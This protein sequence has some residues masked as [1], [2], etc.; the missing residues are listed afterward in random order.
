MAPSLEVRLA[1]TELEAALLA[2]E[3]VPGDTEALAERVSVATEAALDLG[4]PV[5]GRANRPLPDLV[6][7]V[8]P[9]GG[10]IIRTFPPDGEHASG[11]RIVEIGDVDTLVVRAD[12]NEEVSGLIRIGQVVGLDGAGSGRPISAVV[13]RVSVD[14]QGRPVLSAVFGPGD[15][16]AGAYPP[17]TAVLLTQSDRPETPG[18][19]LS[20]EVLASSLV[21]VEVVV[22]GETLS[23]DEAIRIAPRD[24]A[25]TS[26]VGQVA[27]IAVDDGG[28]PFLLVDVSGSDLELGERV[29]VSFAVSERHEVLW[30][31]PE[32]IRSFAGRSFVIVATDDG[33]Q[34]RVEV[35]VGLV[36]AERVE[37]SG[38]IEEGEVVVEP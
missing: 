34:S 18:R 24:G 2:R 32:A 36:T 23:L 8:A 13:N 7:V 17:G 38:A 15:I 26:I 4:L 27:E 11:Q 20:V 31:A 14:Q 35:E 10:T 33:S 9:Q 30:L 29:S 5:D 3:A 19:V 22:E 25:P 1:A 12:L 21:E 28:Q 16:D 37:V 6:A